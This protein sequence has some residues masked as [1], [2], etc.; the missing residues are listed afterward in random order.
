VRALIV[1]TD[2]PAFLASFYA[3]NPGL[4]AA[5]Y[6]EQMIVRSEEP[7]GIA[8]F[9]ADNLRALEVEAVVVHANNRPLQH[10]WAREHGLLVAD[11]ERPVPIG[12]RVVRR[13]VARRAAPHG[14]VEQI[15]AAQVR[16]AKPDLLLLLD[17]MSVDPRLIPSLRRHA[18][19][20]VGQH[21]AT[22]LPYPARE[23]MTY[24]LVV[25][26]FLPTVKQLEAGGV[27]ASLQLLG[28]EPSLVRRFTAPVR[29]RDVAFVGSLFPGLHDTRLAVLEAV[30]SE[31][32]DRLEIWTAQPQALPPTVRSLVRGNAWGADMFEILATAKIAL[33]EHGDIAPY[34]NN[35]RLFEATGMGA[36]LV[37]DA[38]PNLSQLFSSGEVVAYDGPSAAA[39]AIAQLLDDDHARDALAAAGQQRALT[40]HT[41]RA[42]MEQLLDLVSN[43]PGNRRGG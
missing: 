7:F 15:L 25:S 5:S 39:R 4:D 13:V 41:W 3:S 16:R 28:F 26:S 42:R 31:V 37:T 24:D 8:H 20:I 19:L 36:A 30:A 17:I 40:S 34:A 12:Q 18:R 27:P 29:T 23:L 33:N 14:W 35:L 2:Y 43:L 9:Y 10:A 38:K 32:G 21:A 1:N 22:P 6:D 11:A